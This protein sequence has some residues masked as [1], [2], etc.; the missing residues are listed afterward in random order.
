MSEDQGKAL[1]AAVDALLKEASPADGLPEPAERKRLR[2]AGSLSQERVAQALGVRRETV[3]AWEAG[4]SEPRA[5]QRAA[6]IRLLNGLADKFPPTP[7]VDPK[8]SVL[9]AITAA[10]A[11]A[12]SRA[13]GGQ[14]PSRPVSD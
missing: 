4:R 11:T 10:A 14:K 3:S 2:E 8:K 12:P 9:R 6:Y 7:S 13:G 5:P 1:L